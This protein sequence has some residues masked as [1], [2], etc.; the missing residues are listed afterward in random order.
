MDYD[1]LN[2]L[3][4]PNRRGVI[5]NLIEVLSYI[6]EDPLRE[7]LLETP[8]RVLRSYDCLYSGYKKDPAEVFKVFDLEEYDE[9]ILLKNVEFYSTCEH[10]MLPFF[11]KA[12]IAYIPDGNK[13]VGVSKL[14]RLLE[15]YARRLQ[16][17]ERL[18]KQITGAIE[19]YLQPLGS[20]CIIQAQHFC[21]TSRGVQKQSSEMVTSSLTGVFK[22]SQSARLELLTLIK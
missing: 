1:Y 18:T 9:M 10:H 13:V 4:N 15:I 7:G 16:I 8:E 14:A 11:G 5:E 6:G 19:K 17:Q 20:A 12:H 22:N 3:N 21:M 2:D